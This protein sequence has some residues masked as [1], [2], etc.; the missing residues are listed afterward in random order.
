MPEEAYDTRRHVAAST[1]VLPTLGRTVHIILTQAHSE[2]VMRRRTHA[3]SIA[4]RMEKDLWPAGAQAH[5]GN[6]VDAG[7]LA[8]LVVTKVN[9][10]GTINGQALL[11]GC[12][13]LWITHA[14]E[15]TEPGTW[16]WPPKV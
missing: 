13:V 15:G 9:D 7:D 6:P 11:D 1:A 2:Q 12:D 10:D 3:R 8:P 4:Q 14:S 5:I 16:Q